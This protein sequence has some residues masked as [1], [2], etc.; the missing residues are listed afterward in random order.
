[1][2]K[3][4]RGPIL[5]ICVYIPVDTGDTECVESYIA[6][7]SYITAMCD[8]CDA[9]QYIVAGDFNCEPGSRFFPLFQSFATEN[10]LCLSDNSHLFGT[11]AYYNDAGTVSSWIDHMLC[12]PDVDRLISS[13][14]FM[15][16]I[17]VPII[18]HLPL[19]LQILV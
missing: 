13:M 16:I 5:F 10:N 3:T 18:S 2:L 15:K 6:T 12:S 17:S 9:V 4:D 19:C 11:A 1:M 14:V 8:E 7:C